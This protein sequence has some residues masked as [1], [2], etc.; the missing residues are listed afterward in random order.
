MLCDGESRSYNA[1]NEAKVYGFINVEKEDCASHV[2]KHMGTALRNLVQKHKGES[3]ERISG[4]GRL[5]GDL[6]TKL[7]NYY[8]WALKSHSGNVDAMHTAVWATYYHVTSTDNKSNHS[9]CPRGPDSWCKHNAAMAIHE[10]TPKSNYNLPEAVGTALRPVYER[11]SDKKLLQ[12]CQRAKTQNANEALQSVIWS[13]AQ[14]D[15]NV[16]VCR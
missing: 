1:V 16:S 3:G 5:T 12:R 4:K 13:L 15:K 11:L 14:K 2:Q 7:T 9:L 10:P 6:I 8:G